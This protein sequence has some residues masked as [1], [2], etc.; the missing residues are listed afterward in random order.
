LKNYLPLT[1]PLNQSELSDITLENPKDSDMLNSTPLNKPMPPLLLTDK[2][3]MEENLKL[4]SLLKD[5]TKKLKEK[6]VD[7][8]EKENPDKLE[9]PLIEER[10]VELINPKEKEDNKNLEL[11]FPKINPL[12]YSSE[13]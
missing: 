11:K 4:I 6:P 8:K 1:E 2:K 3:L 7:L 12:L 9:N 13:T 10:P 5:L